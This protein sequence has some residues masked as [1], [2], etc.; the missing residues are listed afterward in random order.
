MTVVGRRDFLRTGAGLA[1]ATA[2]GATIASGCAPAPGPLIRRGPGPEVGIDHVVVVMMENR[3]Y[4]HLLGWLPG[5]NSMPAGATFLDD[6]GVEHEPYRYPHWASCGE[7]DP[8]HSR[9]AGLRQLNGGACD[10]WLLDSPDTYP[11][12]YHTA[13]QLGFWGPAAPAWTVCDNYFSAFMGPTWPN[14]FYM[15]CAQTQADRNLIVPVDMT[16]IWDRVASV[17]LEGR[18]YFSDAPFA[19]LLG[20]RHL[21]VSRT[22]DQFL[23]DARQG[24][25]PHVSFVDPRFAISAPFGTSNDYHPFSDIRTGDEFLHTVYEAV[26]RS[27]N[28]ERTVLVVTFDEWGGFADHVVPSVAADLRPEFGLRGFR[29][30][31]L[32]ASPLARRGHVAHGEYDHAS[33]LS[34]IE[35]AFDL[36]PLTPRDAAANNLVDVLDL[37]R[38]ALLDAP[39]WEL[40]PFTPE[41]CV[42]SFVDDIWERL[43]VWARRQGWPV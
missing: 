17:G 19:A 28:W 15:H 33:I 16:T 22:F 43:I 37:D 31:C 8:G 2:L 26:T 4:D 38:G 21:L 39:H 40:D 12:S 9:A 42:A 13:D 36:E 23:L 41:D 35:W 24:R 34:M 1:G 27:P 5:G 29:V 14:R 6:S 3:S 25:L 20:L 7:D 10:G 11:V 30:P 18:Y 32:V